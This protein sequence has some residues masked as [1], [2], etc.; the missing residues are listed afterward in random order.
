MRKS[1]YWQ[2]GKLMVRSVS[3]F[4]KFLV[5]IPHAISRSNL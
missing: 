5:I 2:T 3:Q 4:T 1:V